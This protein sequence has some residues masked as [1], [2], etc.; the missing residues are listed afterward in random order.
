MSEGW[1]VPLSGCWYCNHNSR[2][3]L[4]AAGMV[5]VTRLLRFE[6]RPQQATTQA[7]R[8]DGPC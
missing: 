6:F 4:E 8:V 5:A 1:L 3:I 2:R 7:L